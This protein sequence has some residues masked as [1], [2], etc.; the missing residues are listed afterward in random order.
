MTTPE[1]FSNATSGF[2]AWKEKIEKDPFQVLNIDQSSLPKEQYESLVKTAFA[3]N[4]KV[5]S[6]Y[7]DGRTAGW[8]ADQLG[9]FGV[10]V[11]LDEAGGRGKLDF[12]TLNRVA[13]V[14]SGNKRYG[15]GVDAELAAYGKSPEFVKLFTDKIEQSLSINPAAFDDI[16]QR[17]WEKFS[18]DRIFAIVEQVLEKDP[19][20]LKHFST[21]VGGTVLNSSV[22][23]S[24]F[25]ESPRWLE[26]AEKTL[27][28]H[29]EQVYEISSFMYGR[30]QLDTLEAHPALKNSGKTTI[31][32]M[33]SDFDVISTKAGDVRLETKVG[34]NLENA[35]R[36]ARVLSRSLNENV[37]LKFTHS[38]LLITPTSTQKEIEANFDAQ[39]AE[40]QKDQ[41]IPSKQERD[42]YLDK[43]TDFEVYLTKKDTV[44]LEAQPDANLEN[45]VNR[46]I[47]IS[48]ALN[49]NLTLKF[50]N[51]AMEFTPQS[52]AQDMLNN[53]KEQLPTPKDPVPAREP[54]VILTQALS[55]RGYGIT[56]DQ[57]AGILK[58]AAEGKSSEVVTADMSTWRDA[59]VRLSPG[60]ALTL[61]KEGS[62]QSTLIDQKSPGNAAKPGVLMITDSRDTPKNSSELASGKPSAS[63]ATP[64]RV[65][66]VDSGG[67]SGR[68]S[69]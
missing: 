63:P 67:R 45:A 18:E 40:R 69:M 26:L 54:A 10:K 62:N 21:F 8:F 64:A 33:L 39:F 48:K 47:T 15:S 58:S 11:I 25:K 7:P 19:S 35:V 22:F 59:V 56:L 27:E 38:S 55:E 42:A 20:Q 44:R 31:E 6:E 49:E 53:Y 52:E 46:A 30:L 34:D 28:K 32:R 24:D 2:D 66:E 36:C 5:Y 12:D 61:S 17:N 16:H 3:L 68:G 65:N 57:A 41:G 4:H 37:T 29:P 13:G 43:V 60:A 1:K 14:V 9:A 23:S 50:K 51:I